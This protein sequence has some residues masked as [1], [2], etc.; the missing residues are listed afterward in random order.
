MNS[1]PIVA[2]VWEGKDVVKTGRTMLGATNP[3][4]SAP[5]TIRGDY[6]IVRTR[7]NAIDDRTLDVMSVMAVILLRVPIRRLRCGSRRRNLLIMSLLL[8]R[9]CMRSKEEMS[10]LIRRL[11]E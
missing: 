2:M 11:Y 8:N 3:L 5:G 7:E 10:P 4:A 6:A 9:G 1:G